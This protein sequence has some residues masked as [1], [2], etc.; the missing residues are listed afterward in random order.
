MLSNAQ[1]SLAKQAAQ[2]LLNAGAPA[3]KLNW[4]IAQLSFETSNFSSVEALQDNNLSGITYQNG[5]IQNATQGNPMPA[6][7]SAT[8]HYAHYNNLD[9]WATDYLRILNTVGP[10]RPLDATNVTDFVGALKQNGYFTGDLLSYTKGVATNAAW[11]AKNVL[12]DFI[13]EVKQVATAT[14]N[15]VKKNP[16][17][18]IF[19]I[20]LGIFVISQIINHHATART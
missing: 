1:I 6:S 7:E 10:A 12:A 20:G 13:N 19:V 11:Y 9:D 8:G 2:S 4:L 17:T 5:A 15:A 18:T 16:T 3:N 14:T